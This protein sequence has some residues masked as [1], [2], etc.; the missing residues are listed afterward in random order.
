MGIAREKTHAYKKTSRSLSVKGTAMPASR[1]TAIDSYLHRLFPLCRSITGNENRETLRVLSEL[2]PITLHEYPSGTKVYDWTIPD[3]WRLHRGWIK[4]ATGTLLVDSERTN[5]H[6]MGYSV[7]V[8]GRFSAADLAPH[9]FTCPHNSKAIPYRTSYYARNWGFCITEEDYRRHFAVAPLDARF[10]VCIQA[11]HFPG[12]LTVGE[13]LLP[14]ETRH[15]VLI[16]TYF[17][18]PSLANDNLSGAVLTAFLAQELAKRKNRYSYRIVFIP[19]T[20]GAIAYLAH[21]EDAMR[22]VEEGFVI[23]CVAGRGPHGYKASF[24]PSHRIN[25]VVEEAFAARGMTPLRYAFDPHGS[26]ERQYASPAFR[27]NTATIC[28]DKYYEYPEYHTSLDTLEFISPEA[29]ET[30]LELYLD[31]IERLEAE[32]FYRTTQPH[33]E[34]MLSPRGLYPS[35]GGGLVPEKNAGRQLDCTLW[36]LFHADGHT[37]LES[38][39]HTTG[40]PLDDLARM[41]AILEAKGLLTPLPCPAPRE[42]W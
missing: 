10:E 14:G 21:N 30:S 20:I 32:R 33:G 39:S 19:E 16:S 12:S 7:P 28:K 1:I 8:R 9:L 17:C 34:V 5:L 38:I 35:V 41:A 29:L 31:A 3:E 2:I 42:S 40:L 23:S 11:E 15:E 27:I 36:L 24:N 6:V 22:A 18:H 25:R 4:D 13:V 37:S 26:D